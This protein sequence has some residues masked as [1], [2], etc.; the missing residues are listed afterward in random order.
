MWAI[1]TVT[2]PKSMNF[3][4]RSIMEIPVTISA[5]KR[6]IFVAPRYI[7]W[8]FFFIALIPIAARVPMTVEITAASRVI[9][10]VVAKAVMIV[11]LWKHLLYH[12]SVKPPQVTREVELLKLKKMRTAIGRYKNIKIS[13]I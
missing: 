5:F 4:K 12:S 13:A 7:V 9:C 10:R 11:S 8:F 3:T 2:K 1:S 6:G